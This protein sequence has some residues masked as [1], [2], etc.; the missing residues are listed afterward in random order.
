[1]SASPGMPTSSSTCDNNSDGAS[2]S[3]QPTAHLVL[4]EVDSRADDDEV[5]QLFWE[6]GIVEELTR[7]RTK[8]VAFVTM[9]SA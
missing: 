8:D 5:R 6:Y 1:M 2:L 3:L 9:R 4:E 7:F